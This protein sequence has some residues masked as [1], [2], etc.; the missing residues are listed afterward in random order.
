MCL[1]VETHGNNICNNVLGAY[2]SCDRRSNLCSRLAK[3]LATKMA[4]F[5]LNVYLFVLKIL[6]ELCSTITPII[7][8]FEIGPMGDE[9]RSQELLWGQKRCSGDSP[10]AGSKGRASM[11]SGGGVPISWKHMVITFATMC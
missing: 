10:P 7:A 4:R 3:A 5:E 6:L 9:R 1:H 11:G 8:V 2:R